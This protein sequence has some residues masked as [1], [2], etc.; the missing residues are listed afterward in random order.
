ML[1][2]YAQEVVNRGETIDRY[3]CVTCCK[4]RYFSTSSEI[5]TCLKCGKT[6][7]LEVA[8]TLTVKQ[9]NYVR[10]ETG[11]KC[12]NP[13]C[14]TWRTHIH[15]IDEWAIYHSDDP[16]ILIP[17]CPSCHDQIHNG[18][19]SIS[20][21]TL[22]DWKGIDRKRTLR[23]LHIYVEP[24]ENFKLCAGGLWFANPVE[25]MRLHLFE[26]TPKVKVNFNTQGNKVSLVDISITDIY[27]NIA[28]EVLSNYIEVRDKELECEERN[29]HVKISTNN[30]NRYLPP[31]LV[32][33]MRVK[34]PGF[35]TK[36][37]TVL[38]I[39][40][41]KPGQL[42]LKGCWYDNDQAI[43]MTDEGLTFVPQMSSFVS[44]NSDCCMTYTGNETFIS[45]GSKRG[46]SGKR[47]NLV[48]K[49]SKRKAQKTARKKNRKK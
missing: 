22:I 6:E 10:E 27:G 36:K 42:S 12:A 46:R 2:K 23:N 43:V 16:E 4:G 37:L 13:G 11:G 34:E 35:A 28:V 41:L 49:K 8:R 33:K 44:D 29:G 39:E 24:G 15:H 31:I 48:K 18:A 5:P 40:V 25:K 21:E 26:L 17:V 19:L 14:S 9:K 45:A 7:M 47:E 32:E 20:R 1:P 3:F 30:I 38:E